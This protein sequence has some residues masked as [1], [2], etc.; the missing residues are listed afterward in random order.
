MLILSACIEQSTDNSSTNT[1]SPKSSLESLDST[2]KSEPS[3]SSLYKPGSAEGPAQNVPFPA[4]PAEARKFTED[5][6]KSFTL[7][8]FDLLNYAI[9]ST[10]TK[11][12]ERISEDDCTICYKSIIDEA[13]EIKKA[14][15]WQVGGKHQAVVIDSHISGKNIA[16]VT[17]EFTSDV[18]KVYSAPSVVHEK[19]Q[20]Q[21]ATSLAFDLSY[22][23]GWT[24][25]K[26]MGVE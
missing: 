24:V 18:G 21:D 22:N 25:H 26:I 11:E 19:L 2:P 17:V 1:N 7:Y 6:A 5:G 14:H 8:Y 16:I 9:D 20:K 12:I 15:R 10:D 3:P 23:K 13:E 4:M